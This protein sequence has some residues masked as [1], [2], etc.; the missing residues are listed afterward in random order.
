MKNYLS[1]GLLLISIFLLM[2]CLSNN[3]P[4]PFKIPWSTHLVDSLKKELSKQAF[5]SYNDSLKRYD[6][7]IDSFNRDLTE[8]IVDSLTS[9]YDSYSQAVNYDS[10][11]KAKP[12]LFTPYIK[13]IY[14]KH[15]L[16][17]VKS[18]PINRIMIDLLYYS[19]RLD[20]DTKFDY[21]TLELEMNPTNKQSEMNYRAI[22]NLV[23]LFKKEFGDSL[24]LKSVDAKYLLYFA[25]TASIKSS[26]E[27]DS[28]SA[29]T[30][31]KYIKL[32]DNTSKLKT[33]LVQ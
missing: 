32:L 30:L 20:E 6:V 17:R 5:D 18:I 25:R 2:S 11:G 24:N 29:D 27:N 8:T 13:F 10:L 1:V 26:E 33:K 14:A 3:K 22:E 23:K 16:N 21:E 15:V 4:A 9:E 19:D 12:L 28:F 7:N 31:I